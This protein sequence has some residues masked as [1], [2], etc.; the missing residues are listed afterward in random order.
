MT[1]NP[2]RRFTRLCTSS[3]LY[4]STFQLLVL[5]L[6]PKFYSLDSRL[7]FIRQTLFYLPDT[8]QQT[9]KASR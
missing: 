9:D 4:F 8:K 1:V 3:Q 5:A 6:G 7:W 2:Q